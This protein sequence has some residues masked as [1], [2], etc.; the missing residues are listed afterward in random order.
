MTHPERP[1]GPGPVTVRQ[2]ATR[3]GANAGIDEEALMRER[4]HPRWPSKRPTSIHWIQARL[5][6]ESGGDACQ[7]R[8]ISVVG[9]TVLVERLPAASTTALVIALPHRLAALLGRDDL[10]LFRGT[11]F[12][13]VSELY[14]VL[15]IATGPREIADELCI[16]SGV[17]RLENGETV[18]I[19]AVD[20]AQPSLQLLA[21]VRVPE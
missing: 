11:P 8:L 2:P 16:C 6:F 4:V 17:S 18:E 3:H 14:G 13:L 20:D 7:C 19:P 15:G 5:A 10:T 12:G 21:A 9:G 1:E